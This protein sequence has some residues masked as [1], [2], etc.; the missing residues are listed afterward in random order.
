MTAVGHP[1]D[2][3]KLSYQAIDLAIKPGR[4]EPVGSDEYLIAVVRAP[5]KSYAK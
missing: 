5:F 2:L 1:F 3:F 4:V